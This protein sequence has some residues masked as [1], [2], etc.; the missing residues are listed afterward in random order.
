MYAEYPKRGALR[1]PLGFQ[2]DQQLFDPVFLFQS[3]ETVV[4]AIGG[5]LRLRLAGSFRLRYLSLHAIKRSRLRPIANRGMGVG[6]LAHRS[7]ATMLRNQEVG[8]GIGFRQLLMQFAERGLEILN[9]QLLIGD[10]LRKAFTQLLVTHAALQRGAG[11]IVLLL[12]D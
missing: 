8:L 2:L 10:L 11:K 5:E 6:S 12:V 7:R 4:N 1:S 3:S 9:L